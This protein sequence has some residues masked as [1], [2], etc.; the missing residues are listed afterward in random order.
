MRLVNLTQFIPGTRE[1]RRL[2]ERRRIKQRM[3]FQNWFPGFFSQDD[4]PRQPVPDITADDVERIVR[5][6]FP[7]EDFT[8]VMAI[9]NEYGTQKWQRASPRVQL[10]VLKLA[11]GSMTKLRTGI[12]LAKR[13]YRDVLVP[14]E[15]PFS[16]KIGYLEVRKLI[17]VER[18]RIFDSDWKQYEDWLKR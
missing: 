9:L 13:D 2:K 3:F 12:D 17:K 10:A 5:R 8:P 16:Q 18:R 15:Y 4:E 11:N 6:D 7:A 14:A 1:W